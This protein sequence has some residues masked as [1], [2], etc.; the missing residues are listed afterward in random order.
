MLRDP[1]RVT[2]GFNLVCINVLCYSSLWLKK[3]FLVLLS[4]PSVLLFSLVIEKVKKQIGFDI[5]KILNIFLKSFFKQD[6]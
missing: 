4:Y 3:T 6:L 2:G 1:Q 5:I